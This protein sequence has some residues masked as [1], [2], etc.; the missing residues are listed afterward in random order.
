M[1]SLVRHHI[2]SCIHH[3]DIDTPA[4]NLLYA[5]VDVDLTAGWTVGI[6]VFYM[7]TRASIRHATSADIL[8]P[9][10]DVRYEGDL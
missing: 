4:D 7:V 9:L 6:R 10:K 3:Y 5:R 2:I 1:Y 8:V